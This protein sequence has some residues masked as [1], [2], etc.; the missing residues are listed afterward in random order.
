MKSLHVRI[1]SIKS[2][3]HTTQ[4]PKTL[5]CFRHKSQVSICCLGN[6][7]LDYVR[8]QNRIQK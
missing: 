7:E 8:P 4:N 5:T 6:L 1:P 3:L 2:Q